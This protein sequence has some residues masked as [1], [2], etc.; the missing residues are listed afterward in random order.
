MFLSKFYQDNRGSVLLFAMV[1]GAISFTLI[2][3]GVTGYAILENRASVH[4]HSREMAFQ[5]AE[6][7]VNYYRW[8]LAHN[9]TD[10]TD[11]TGLAGPYL[12]EYV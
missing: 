8:H 9:K 2:V 6:A 3:M 12:K 1:F 4:K 7:G 5:I 11:G 10:Y